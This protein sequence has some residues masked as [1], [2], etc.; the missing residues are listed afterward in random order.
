MSKYDEHR[1]RQR[2]NVKAEAARRGIT[3][4][5]RGACY[6][7]TA[8]NLSLLVDDLAHID[9]RDFNPHFKGERDRE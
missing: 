6:L 9:A 2:E 8:P 1:Q 5:P 4:I 7:L 3:I